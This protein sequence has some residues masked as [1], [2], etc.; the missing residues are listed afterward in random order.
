[1]STIM[2]QKHVWA[3]SLASIA[4]IW[5][6]LYSISV[7]KS[8]LKNATQN[9]LD[10]A[11]YKVAH[12]YYVHL[13]VQQ[14]LITD[15]G[16]KCPKDTTLWVAFGSI[17]HWLLHNYR[18]L[19]IH[20]AAKRPV[21]APSEMW[22]VTAAAISPLFDKIAITFTKIQARNIVIS[23]Q[24]Q[25]MSKL[26]IDIA[27]SLDIRPATNEALEGVDPLTIITGNDWFILKD[28]IVMHIQG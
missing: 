19:M 18:R 23:Q 17:L 4:R 15:M 8:A 16:S 25:E 20:N 7:F 27:A 6:S 5:E 24:Q 26:V 28:S 14:N 22:W 13:R 3:F 10:Q 11:F 12:A 2:N 9:V 1:M 21:Q